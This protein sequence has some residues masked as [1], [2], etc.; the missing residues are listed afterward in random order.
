MENWR[1]YLTEQKISYTE[2]NWPSIIEKAYDYIKIA[3]PPY[4]SGS[5]YLI[6]I[7]FIKKQEADNH[8]SDVYGE[9]HELAMLPT[10]NLITAFFDSKKLR[11]YSPEEQIEYFRGLADQ[12]GNEDKPITGGQ[13]RSEDVVYINLNNLET[14]FEYGLVFAKAFFKGEGLPLATEAKFA[15]Y[16]AAVSVAAI[17][18]HEVSHA[19][20]LT[21]GRGQK[22]KQ[23]IAKLAKDKL[24]TGIEDGVI[25]KDFK[26]E[27][28]NTFIGTITDELEPLIQANARASEKNARQVQ[29]EFQKEL[30]SKMA[31][32]KLPGLAAHWANKHKI[33][34]SA[35]T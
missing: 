21:A 17:I 13:R 12:V 34:L 14:R 29:D 32:N 20:D 28:V 3:A 11:V 30:A 33:E 9:F 16:F 18:V 4:I 31:K 35:I 22:L 1:D 23:H 5:K 6:N 2:P 15:E 26:Y 8:L 27:D 10:V 7:K 25:S 24:E 19:E